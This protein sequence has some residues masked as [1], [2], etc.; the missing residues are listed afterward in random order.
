M[1]TFILYDMI[2]SENKGV[3]MKNLNEEVFLGITGKQLKEMINTCQKNQIDPS[4]KYDKGS[5]TEDFFRT[6]NKGHIRLMKSYAM[7]KG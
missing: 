2:G 5:S 3:G 4:A 1:Q 6:I 7:N